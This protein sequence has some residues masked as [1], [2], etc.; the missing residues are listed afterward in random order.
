MYDTT[1]CESVSSKCYNTILFYINY[2]CR[3]RRYV[4]LSPV[5]VIIPFRDETWNVLLRTMH[6]ILDRAPPD[7]L[8]EIVLVDDGSKEGIYYLYYSLSNS[9]NLYP[10]DF[11]ALVV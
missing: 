4:N 7:L 3:T 2:R 11:N 5:S 9:T 1:V 8:K 10:V 6:S